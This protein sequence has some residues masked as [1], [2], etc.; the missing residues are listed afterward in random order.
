MI[1]YRDASHIKMWFWKSFVESFSIKCWANLFNIKPDVVT[2]Y[3]N[4]TY[5]KMKKN[6]HM[7]GMITNK[8]NKISSY[9]KLCIFER[10]KIL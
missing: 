4:K 6:R 1:T 9:E 10:K 3:L 8:D 5:Y 7:K 2:F